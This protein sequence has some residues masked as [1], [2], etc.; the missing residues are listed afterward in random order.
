MTLCLPKQLTMPDTDIRTSVVI[1]G[2]DPLT[3]TETAAVP[4]GAFVVAADSGLDRATEAGI[5]VHAAVG[6][7]DSVTASEYVRAE[8][9]GVELIRLDEVKDETDLELALLHA[10]APNP[11]RLIVVGLSGGRFDHHLASVLL[12]A[13]DRFADIE[14]EGYV[15]AAKVTVIR[16][17]RAL[18]GRVGDLVSLIPINGPAVG[19]STHG[20]EYPLVKE[21]LEPSSPRGV[22]NILT[23]A[24]AAVSLESGVLLG[25]QTP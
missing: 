16:S 4:D 11:D 22:S 8:E 12:L 20:L 24:V 9:Q 2:G 1:S 14:V 18:T 6:D 17:T 3:P 5:T 21:T 23:S 10:I 19:V 15:G 13:D 7:F 25:V